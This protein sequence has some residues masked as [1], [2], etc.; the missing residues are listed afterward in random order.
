MGSGAGSPLKDACADSLYLSASHNLSFLSLFYIVIN[1]H[2]SL[3]Y[4]LQALLSAGISIVEKEN[5]SNKSK[6]LAYNYLQE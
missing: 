2:T 3:C 6:G 4:F 5:Y 1:N